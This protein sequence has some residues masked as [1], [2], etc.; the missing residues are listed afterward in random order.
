M[1]VMA[2]TTVSRRRVVL[3]A[4]A[5]GIAGAVLAV[6]GR[7]RAMTQLASFPR[8]GHLDPGLIIIV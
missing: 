2:R 7:P 6:R 8:H 5:A 1:M 3:G 4:M